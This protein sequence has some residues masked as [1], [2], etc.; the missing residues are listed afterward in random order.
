MKRLFAAATV[1]ILL[2]APAWAQDTPILDKVGAKVIDSYKSSSCEDL[3]A[4][5]TEP[6][7]EMTIKAVAFLKSNPTMREKFIDKVAAPIAN[8]LF[9]CGMIP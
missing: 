6:P 8:N 2:A 5:K 3:K 9:E 4:K 1:S 7:S